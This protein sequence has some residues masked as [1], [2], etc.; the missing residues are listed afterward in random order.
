MKKLQNDCNQYEQG[1][2]SDGYEHN[3]KNEYEQVVVMGMNKMIGMSMNKKVIVMALK[4]LKCFRQDVIAFERVRLIVCF[5]ETIC[6]RESNASELN[7]INKQLV[8]FK[9]Y[10]VFIF[11]EFVVK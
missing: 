7:T 10:E 8:T 11:V 1:S 3:D 5:R 9:Y 4:A 2:G 6:S